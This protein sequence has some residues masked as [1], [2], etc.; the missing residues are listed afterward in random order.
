MIVFISTVRASE[1][2]QKTINLFV[3]IENE[4][5]FTYSIEKFEFD[6]PSLNVEF[7]RQNGG[8]M[9]AETNIVITTNV[10]SYFQSGY[11]VLPNKLSSICESNK[12]DDI[13][14]DFAEYYIGK[15]RLIVGESIVFDDFNRERDVLW[16]KK[17][18]Y[19]DF[20]Q[21]NKPLPNA[22][23]CKGTAVLLVELDF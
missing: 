2:T 15:E 5:F 20:S 9:D 14:E 11:K 17:P 3:E 16:V 12:G 1:V 13:Q 8:L 21:L 22:S 19:I 6:Q 18:F 10:P 7:D 4:K 23:Y